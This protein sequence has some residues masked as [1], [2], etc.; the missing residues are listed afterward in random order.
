MKLRIFYNTNDNG[1]GSTS[2]TFFDSF[3]LSEFDLKFN[4]EAYGIFGGETEDIYVESESEMTCN[5]IT[6]PLKYLKERY[7]TNFENEPLYQEFLDEF[8]NG[9]RPD[10]K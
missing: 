9:E 10:G 6:T 4:E 1:D 5:Y 2:V 8:F 7:D 3:E